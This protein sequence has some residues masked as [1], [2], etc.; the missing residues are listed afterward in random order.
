MGFAMR[1]AAAVVLLFFSIAT[2]ARE[3]PDI[4]FERFTLE[5]GLNVVVHTDRK[6][7]IVAVSVWYHVGSKDEPAGK[8]GFAHLFEHL[9][10]NGSENYNDEYFGPFEK[11]G[12]TGMNGTTFLDRTN[13]FQTVPNTALDM[14]L[15]MESDRMGHLLG[16]V[17]QAKLDE[18]RGVVQNEK[19]EGENQPYGALFERLQSASFP[20]GHPYHHTTIG[21]MDDL[22]AASLDDVKAWF[23]RWYGA[24]NATLVLAG[25]IDVDTAKVKVERYF[26]HLA[27]GPAL[28]RPERWVAKRNESSMQVIHDRVPQVRWVRSWN[29][30][31]LGE[32]DADYLDLAAELLGGGKTSRLYKRLVYEEQVA[33]RVQIGNSSYELAGMFAISVDIKQGVD[34]A[35][36]EAI[37]EDELQ[38][39]LSDGPNAADLERAQ[40]G[41][42]ASFVRGV[43]RIG[44][45]GGKADVLASGQTY[46]N[47]P[48]YFRKALR[49]TLEATPD[50]VRD[51]AQRWL[52]SGDLTIITEPFAARGTAT[53]DPVDR[54]AGPPAVTEFP[55]VVIPAVQ[56]ATLSNG[57]QVQFARRDAVPTVYVSALFDGGYTTDQGGKLGTA[58]LTMAMLDEGA[59][60]YSA[61]ELAERLET[62]GA[63]LSSS[64]SLDHA[65][66]SLSALSDQLP[67]SLALMADVLRRP[68]FE[69]SELD[70]LRSRWVASIAQE[71]AQPVGLALRLLPPLLYGEG[72]PYAIPFTGS[73]TVES[74]NAITQADLQHWHQQ[75]LRP[76]GMRL[77][78]VGDTELD[79]ILPRLEQAFG[80]WKSA[81]IAH[82][83]P[84]LAPPP[85]PEQA[86]VYLLD[87]PGAPQS[88]VLAGLI[89][90]PVNAPDEAALDAAVSILG[91]LFSSRLN[92]N[93]REDKHWAYGAYSILS[94]ARGPRPLMLYA[95]VESA[96][97]ADALGEL[98]RELSDYL[99]DRPPTA[100]EL[101]KINDNQI[102]GLPGQFETA[103]A[104][105]GAML[106]ILR[107]DRPDDW[108]AQTK[109]RL[110]SVT[111]EET[112]QAA[113]EHIRAERLIWL[114]VGDL[115]VIEADVRA[116][117]LGAVQVLDENGAVL[118]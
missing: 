109:T 38:A 7:P 51:A 79:E 46:L 23:D 67:E 19:R 66:V 110:E 18:Q 30:A 94:D 81:A 8:S 85:A 77:V 115:K 98:R 40:T 49:R 13:Y 44:G 82:T 57:V 101:K 28:T 87:R 48:G 3:L 70:R 89:A 91:G 26:G 10:F 61:L 22:N 37:V 54:S 24:A 52:A 39:L 9:M 20:L 75:H 74:V 60:D 59:G 76:Q 72:H 45:F 35:R 71:Q 43:E 69:Q 55:E 68:R 17:D 113:I 84:S 111:I 64:A 100:A 73:G 107:Y 2:L 83:A 27:S 15:W 108:V 88:L 102:R 118:R 14:A 5:N 41:I 117:G 96:H 62:L 114:V 78:V 104:V 4:P 25:D 58:G 116:L 36:V 112:A 105:A 95:P 86:T 90:P 33:D 50:Q 11:V 34:V 1:L 31:P 53:D 63:G 47:D 65:T 103:G 97:T 6:A 32:A 21:S 93:L 42:E 16:V 56:T 99:G 92:M 80:D 29:V 106:G 12:A